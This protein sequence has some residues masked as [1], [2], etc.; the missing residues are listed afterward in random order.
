VAVKTGTSNNWRDNWSVGY[1]PYVTVGV[2]VGNFDGRPMHNVSGVTG[3]GP[4]FREV[5]LAAMKSRPKNGF[6]TG[7]LVVSRSICPL[8]GKLAGAHCPNR[9]KELFLPGTEPA[10]PCDY[11][12]RL[13]IDRRN[14]LLAG[15]RCPRRHAR[16]TVFVV[17][18][19]KYAEWAKKYGIGRAPARYSPH[20][21]RRGAA[22]ARKPRVTSPADNTRYLVDPSRP[23]TYQTLPLR[24][25]V[26]G[27]VDRVTWVVDGK[28]YRTV[29]WPFSAQWTLSEGTHTVAVV[30][31]GRS[32]DEVEI[33]VK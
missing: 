1:T 17:Y 16:S 19:P 26:H 13:K 10:R 12:Q 21:P 18:P 9:M 14:G 29:R 33:V 5:M 23:R 25:V 27:A 32:S 15:A 6:E 22:W 31:N 3:A 11:H 7:E 30:A 28:P 24:A 20:C 2:W 8:S 4:I